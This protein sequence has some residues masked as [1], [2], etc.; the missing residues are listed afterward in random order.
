MLACK[1]VQARSL[2]GQTWKEKP[3]PRQF[4]PPTVMCVFMTMLLIVSFPKAGSLPPTA[5]AEMIPGNLFMVALR[6]H[7]RGY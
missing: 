3:K 5:D 7:N 4:H 2:L 6:E 1:P